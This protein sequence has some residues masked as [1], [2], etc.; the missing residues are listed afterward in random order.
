MDDFDDIVTD[1]RLTR[2]GCE[3]HLGY[4]D[5]AGGG[6]L[7]GEYQVVAS[8]GSS[9]L[10]G[11]FV[12]GWDGW[13]LLWASLVRFQYRDWSGDPAL[14]GVPRV[15]AAVAASSPTHLS[16]ALSRTF[17]TPGTPR[18]LFPVSRPVEQIVSGLNDLQPTL[19]MCYSSFLPRLAAEAEAGRLRIAPRRVLAISEPLLPEVRELAERTWRAPIGI[20]Y[21]MSEGLF[22]GSCGYGTHLPDD[23]CLV[24]T[25]D[26]RGRPVAPGTTSG[27]VYL[28]TLYNHTLPLIRYDVTDELTVLEGPCPCGSGMRRIADP[29]G[30]LDDTFTYGG[31]SVHPHLFRS[32]LGR[33][34][35]IIEYQV[36]QTPRGALIRVV[37]RSRVDTDA[38]AQ[39]L[40][41]ALCGVGVA[42]ARV[43]LTQVATLDRQ[44]SGKLRRFVPLPG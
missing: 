19:L 10:R 40:G 28:T 15:T 35:E 34:P 22:T 27:R 8:G 20:S 18:V 23:L 13:A 44:V 2:A 41:H 17:S 37:A 12:Y 21:G 36:H 38:L 43:E 26:D 29:Q 14:V 25:V 11:M 32:A 1:P 4:A 7:H 6:Y 9:G 42:R 5:E 31:V 16:A 33:S 24:E 30:R 39:H 3:R